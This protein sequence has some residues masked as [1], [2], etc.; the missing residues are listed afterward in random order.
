MT[1]AKANEV[2]RRFPHRDK[3]PPVVLVFG[4]DRGLVTE[5]SDAI[6]ALFDDSDDP[7]AIVKL[8]AATVT[9]DPARLIDEAGTISMFGGKRLILVRDAAGRNMSP[10]V[11]PLLD[12]PPTEA[13]VVVEAGD[14]KRGTGLRKDVENHARAV[15]IYCPADTERD[16]DRMIDE[17]AAKFGLA[18]DADA[19]AMLRERLGAD[20]AAS[21][22]EVLKACLHAADGEALT[23]ADIDAVVGDVAASQIG[24]AVDAA[25]LGNRRALDAALGRVLRQD[26]AAV[27]ILMMAQRVCHALELASAAVAQGASPTRAVEELRP[28][29]FGSQ[30]AMAPRALDQWA[31]GKLRAASEAIAEATFRTRIMPH[32]AAATTRDLLF[33]IA[34]QV[35]QR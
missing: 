6:L 7:F 33:R 27:Q 3:L 11:V 21:R 32:L 4:P 13:V 12:R 2:G 16:L 35:S 17:E 29:L 5:V 10:A 22:G 31:P 28:P 34:S 15:A 26:S 19:R 23:T 14:L 20:R 25:F 9:A 24:E 8:D 18:V 30:R 1:A